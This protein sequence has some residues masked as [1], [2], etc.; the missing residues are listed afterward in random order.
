VPYRP[1]L[2]NERFRPEFRIPNTFTKIFLVSS[3]ELY[4]APSDDPIFPAVPIRL[5]SSFGTMYWNDLKRHTI[6]ACTNSIVLRHPRSGAVWYPYFSSDGEL[7]H[8]KWQNPPVVSS[9]AMLNFS[10]QIPD[11]FPGKYGLK[12]LFEVHKQK[13][14]VTVAPLAREQWKV[15]A[16]RLFSIKL[17][18]LQLDVAGI[19]QGLGRD[20]AGAHNILDEA[21]FGDACKDVK[22]QAQGWKNISVAGLIGFLML[23]A[24]IVL[25]TI[26]IKGTVAV[27]RLGKL[28]YSIA[29][30]IMR[31][32]TESRMWK[33]SIRQM[34]A[35]KEVFSGRVNRLRLS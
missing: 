26:N 6:L 7:I 10:V 11:H 25:S 33:A 19:A 15:E 35:V 14:V 34:A 30:W 5:R 32:T 3:T 29:L 12:D 4:S 16:R 20:L 13:T 24:A 23:A 27:V 2:Y 28:L 1:V 18:R 8:S 21:G 22:I 17:A 31:K 9:I